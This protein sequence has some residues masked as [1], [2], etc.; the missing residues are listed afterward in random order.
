MPDSR[1]VNHILLLGHVNLRPRD[2]E[3]GTQWEAGTEVPKGRS[4]GQP[5]STVGMSKQEKSRPGEGGEGSKGA[6]RRA[7]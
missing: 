5:Q 1:G 7:K 3:Y 6:E 4:C 2:R